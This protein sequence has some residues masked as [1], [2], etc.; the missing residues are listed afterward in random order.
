MK[1]VVELIDNVLMHTDNEALIAKTSKDVRDLMNEF[2][3]YA[4]LG[5]Q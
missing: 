3:L 4:E 2:P 5:Y 1:T